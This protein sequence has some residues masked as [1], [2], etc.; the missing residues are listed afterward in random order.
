MEAVIVSRGEEIQK[1]KRK[2]TEKKERVRKMEAISNGKKKQ[3]GIT[4]KCFYRT[5]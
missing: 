2:G 1:M 3:L 4:K 5:G